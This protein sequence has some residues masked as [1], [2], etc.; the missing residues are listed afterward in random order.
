MTAMWA[1][2]FRGL[3]LIKTVSVSATSEGSLTKTPFL[4]SA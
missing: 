2:I 4:D 3:F 1:D